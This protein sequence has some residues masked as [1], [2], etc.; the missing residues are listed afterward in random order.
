MPAREVREPAR[1]PGRELDSVMKSLAGLR[2]ASELDS[3]M[4]FGL[5]CEQNVRFTRNNNTDTLMWRQTIA[6]K[7]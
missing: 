6:T 1:K 7:K 5:H 2:P 4:E 3:V